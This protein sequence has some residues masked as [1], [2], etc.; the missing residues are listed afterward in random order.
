M[1]LWSPLAPDTV[2]GVGPIRQLKRPQQ[3]VLVRS[4]NRYL[5]ISTLHAEC[6][7]L[8]EKSSELP[9]EPKRLSTARKSAFGLTGVW[10][11]Q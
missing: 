3:M 6:V 1:V 9:A 11:Q 4:V 8:P 2:S 7:P 10:T 5:I